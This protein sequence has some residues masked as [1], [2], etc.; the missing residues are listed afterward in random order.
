MKR[1]HPWNV[2][3][4]EA[5]AIQ[6]TLKGRLVLED[7]GNRIDRIA[8]A[9][10]AY[11]RGTGTLYA[12][13]AI[14]SFPQLE[15]L[16]ERWCKGVSQ[17]PYIPGLLSF[18]EV[19]FLLKVLNRMAVKP[20]LILCDGQ[21][22]AHPRGLGLACHLGIWTGIPTVGC[23]KTRLVGEYTEPGPARGE[24]SH[25]TFKGQRVGAVVRTRTGVKPIFVSQGYG[26]TLERSIEVTLRAATR[27]RLPDPIRSAHTMVT[28]L[29]EEGGSAACR[30]PRSGSRPLCA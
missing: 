2:S 22:I 11:A 28:R 7:L 13:I 27:F 21:G 14:L 20:D 12:G 16:E 24:Y 19:P 10:I 29:R 4:Q 18:R 23:A 5:V 8:G 17:F 25:L 30:P 6:E 1:L 26:M 3:Y 9:D 15:P